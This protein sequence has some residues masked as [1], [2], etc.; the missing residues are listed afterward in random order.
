MRV[1]FK[2][3]KATLK[4][5]NAMNQEAADFASEIAP[6]R[7]ISISHSADHSEGVVTVWYWS[8]G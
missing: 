3:F 1:R 8:E 7:L 5:W 4:S 6:D 2:H